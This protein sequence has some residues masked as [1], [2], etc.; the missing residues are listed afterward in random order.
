MDGLGP[1]LPPGS[2][3]STAATPCKGI[4]LFTQWG[5]I[6]SPSPSP[7]GDG[8]MGALVRPALSG[9]NGGKALLFCPSHPPP[10]YTNRIFR[11]KNDNLFSLLPHLRGKFLPFLPLP[12]ADDPERISSAKAATLIFATLFCK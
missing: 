12:S 4:S 8:G 9:Q 5:A 11:F 7:Q 2:R 1:S 3:P 10:L 6:A